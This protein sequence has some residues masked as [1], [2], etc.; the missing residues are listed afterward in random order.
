MK[1]EKLLAFNALEKEKALSSTLLKEN[2]SLNKT[3][4]K[5]ALLTANSFEAK[6]FKKLL[7]RQIVTAK[8]V[9]AESIEVC[10]TLAENALTESGEKELYIQ[11]VNPRN[12]VIADKGAI[13]FGDSSLIY[14]LKKTVNYSNEVIDICVNVDADIDDQPLT[15]GTYFISI[16]HEDRKLGNTQV[17]LN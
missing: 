9:K 17:I 8:A 12:N 16:F 3:I 4:E 13:N 15:K 14:S 5:G 2:E 7:G 1:A 11:I 10:F 6:A